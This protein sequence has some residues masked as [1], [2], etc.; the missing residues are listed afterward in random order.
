L[1]TLRALEDAARA[2][3]D[4]QMLLHA[5]VQA[6]GFYEGAGYQVQ[7]EPWQEAGIAHLAMLRS[8]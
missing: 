6:R 2:R 3:G 7:G 8:L 1:Q 5:Q 4:R